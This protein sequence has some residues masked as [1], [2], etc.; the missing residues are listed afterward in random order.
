MAARQVAT[1]QARVPV[2]LYGRMRAHLFPGDG[3]PHGAALL[4]GIAASGRRPRLLIRDLIPARD[5]VD[6]VRG[7]DGRGHHR[8]TAAFVRDA[9]LAAS[10]QGLAYL[11]VHVHGGSGAV[12]FSGPDRASHSRG[13]PALV[14]MLAGAP[15]APLVFAEGAVDGEV[16][17]PDGRVERVG[18][19]VVCGPS[20][21]TLRSGTDTGAVRDPLYDRQSRLFGDAGQALLKTLKVGVIGAG[22]LG[23]LLVEYLARLGVGSLVVIDP[24]RVEPSNL[25]RLP[26]ARR[27]DALLLL[28]TSRWSAA[29]AFAHRFARPKV[30]MARR[31][32]R[33]AFGDVTFEPV[34]EDVREPSAAARLIDA[35]YIFLAADSDQARFLFNAICQQ[36]L[37]PGAQL[38]A[39]VR[40]DP[41]D[42]RVLD[43]HSIVR[44]VF[45][46]E[47]CLWCNSVISPARMAEESADPTQ[48]RVQRYVDDPD[49]IAPSVVTLNATAASIAANDFLFTVT[50]LTD[51][52]ATGDWV[53]VS[54]AQRDTAYVGPR[55]D[56]NCPECSTSGRLGRG[57]R[58]DRLP[59]FFR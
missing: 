45:P 2:D 55:R 11:P 12:G 19:L 34:F 18:E 38:G 35:D 22:G 32:A 25:P 3:Q 42:G 29:R 39:K 36:Y 4:A 26:G 50:G 14:A 44:A 24:D 10:E 51:A 58:G 13:Y 52:A 53:K 31:L 1:W 15:V 54:P 40:T 28:A 33:E 5:G 8:L 16:W 48:R 46:G 43:V 20:H 21:V 41:A 47:G 30:Q 27:R 37:I 6:Y 9:V 59:M 49:V 56:P 23:M 17:L 57:D 7:R